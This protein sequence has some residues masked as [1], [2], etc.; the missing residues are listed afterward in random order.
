[1]ITVLTGDNSFGLSVAYRQQLADFEKQHG[2]IGIERLAGGEISLDQV[3]EALNSLPFLATRKLVVLRAPSQQKQFMEQFEALINGLP[4]TTDL[5]IVEPRLDKRSKW[6][7]FI[8]THSELIDFPELDSNGLTRWLSQQ[9]AAREGQLDFTDAQYLVHRVG[10]NQQLLDTTLKTLLLYA[11]KITRETIMVMTESSPQSSVFA[12]LDAAFT[13]NAALT[14]E[15]YAEQRALRVEPQQIV[16]MLA[17]Q[18]HILALIKTAGGRM[19]DEIAR[20]A[21]VSPYVVKKSLP[22]ARKLSRTRLS[23]LISTLS[24]YD[25]RAKREAFN[26]DEA[27]PSYL[28]T[29][30]IGV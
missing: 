22:I 28:L 17:W 27:L 2:A 8:R 5:L 20:Q 19:P 1:M 29:I 30:A 10:L 26:L 13:G 11:P 23:V 21:K 14:L 25:A 12:L 6:Y 7:K 16:A 18:L 24:S 9:A 15:L 3:S 4:D